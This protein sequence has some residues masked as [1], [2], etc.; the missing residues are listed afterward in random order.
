VA[1]PDTVRRL[2]VGRH[3]DFHQPQGAFAEPGAVRGYWIELREK[4]DSPDWPPPW[5]P[6][7]GFHRFIAT[8]QWGL[9][10]FDRYLAGDGEA[11]L[12]GAVAACEYLVAEQIAGG[13][14]EGAWVEPEDY[15]H[16]FRMRGPWVSAMAQGHGASLLARVYGETGRDEFAEASRR[17]LAI[18]DVPT[19]AG[20]AM[21]L[22]GGRP[23]PEEYPTDPPSHVLNGAIY[24]L[25]GAYDVAVGLGDAE[26]RSRWDELVDTLATNLH[27]WDLRYWSLYDLYPHPGISNAASPSYHELHISQLRA[28]ERLAPRPEIAA[29]AARFEAYAA[30]RRTKAAG[31]AHKVAFRLAVPRNERIAARLP[32]THSGH[33]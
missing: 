28:L 25:W 20:G 12:A 30:R 5:Y 23:F 14:R 6:F 17:A 10:A 21:A 19:S 29:T 15:P 4:A 11:F 9:G 1:L 3:S 22:L 24:A 16:T 33:G 31:F 13:P 26:A 7:P 18:Y 27:R 2:V 8:G 32:W